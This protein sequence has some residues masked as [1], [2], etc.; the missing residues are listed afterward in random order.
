MPVGDRE[1]QPVVSEV[2]AQVK[3][4]DDRE[5]VEGGHERWE[6]VQE[7]GNRSSRRKRNMK[8]RVT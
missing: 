6:G 8:A 1:R 4:K 2:T 5:D 3:G 7:A